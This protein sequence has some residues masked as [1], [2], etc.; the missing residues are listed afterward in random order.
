MENFNR[1][2]AKLKK[3]LR[4]PLPG[5]EAHLKM[6]SRARLNEL[7]GKYDTSSAKQSSVLILL[8]P[9]K[10]SVFTVLMKRNSYNGVH[11]GQISFPGGSHEKSDGSFIETALREA[12]EEVGILPENVKIIGELSDMYIPP[13]NFMVHPIV[14][15]SKEKP[16]LIPDATEVAQIIEANLTAIFNETDF[17]E[18]ELDVRGHKIKTPCYNVN[19]H[20][21]WGATAMMLSE[22]NE[23]VLRMDN[24]WTN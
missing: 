17:K 3:Q 14:G 5:K 11:S 7:K 8:Y 10:A 13:S 19:G 20:V 4:K 6:A 15:F 16:H 1:F 22:L 21:V 9:F 2:I 24:N 18:M 23:V 12:N